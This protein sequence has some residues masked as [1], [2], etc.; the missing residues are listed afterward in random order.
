MS[1][2]SNI[3]LWLLLLAVLPDHT[4]Y[5][6][7]WIVLKNCSVTVNG[8]TNINKFTCTVPGY[9]SDDTL[10][11]FRNTDGATIKMKG[12]LDIPVDGFDCANA[13]MTKDLRKTIQ[14]KTFPYLRIQFI[15]L[16]RYPALK[17]AEENITGMVG[18]ELAGVK[19]QMEINYTIS[20]DE[21]AVVS[22]RGTQ[23]IRFSDF[24]LAAPRKLGGMIK[25][26]DRLDVMFTIHCRIIKQ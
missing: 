8:S 25:T 3:V 17:A 7:K 22:L 10:T 14:S 9:E 19:K 13:M 5:E 26:D 1:I 11:C 20:M 2:H 21:K 15:A 18:I 16:E 6:T 24:N 4:S 12:R 23:S